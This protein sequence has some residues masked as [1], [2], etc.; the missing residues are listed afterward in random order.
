VKL[1]PVTKPPTKVVAREVR[2]GPGDPNYNAGNRGRVQVNIY[3]QLYWSAV[4]RTF[5]RPTF[6]EV[7]SGYHPFDGLKEVDGE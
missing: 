5:N 2:V 7:V 4:D 6:A 3:E 1:A